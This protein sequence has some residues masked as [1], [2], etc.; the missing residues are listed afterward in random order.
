MNNIKNQIKYFSQIFL[1]PVYMLSH[2]MPR[3]KK[4]WVLGS[5][6]GKRFADNPR[7][8]Y[9][10]LNQFKNG[11]VKAIW[12]SKNKNIIRQLN[13]NNLPA[14]YLYSL[15]GVF[16]C[17]RA[18]V[19]LYDNYS[20]DICF[21]LSGGAVKINMWHGIPLKKI[22][23]DNKFDLVRH[24]ENKFKKFYWKLRRMTDEKPRD[25]VITTS[26]NLKKIFSSA[27]NT[28]NVIV[29][30]YPR[31]DVLCNNNLK[32]VLLE[33]EKKAFQDI[34][35]MSKSKKIIL[36][37]P[38]FRESES[39]FFDII[40]I[41]RFNRFLEK[42]NLFLCI[43]L[44]IKSKL[45]QEFEKINSKNI[46]VID[47]DIDLY[48]FFKYTNILITDYSSTYFDYLNLNKKII[49]FNYDLKD[50]LEDSREMYFDYNKA[51]PGRKVSTQDELEKAILEEDIF[52]KKREHIKNKV[53][54]VKDNSSENLFLN[55]KIITKRKLIIKN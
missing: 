48:S 44:H 1:I 2:L 52:E 12:I 3:N 39:K 17:L 40:D 34:K 42:N 33:N 19:Y 45:K 55:I 54:G 51:T 27:F 14:Y 20:K 53:I 32:N 22:N 36:Y 8:F 21:T 49:F 10:Y 15:K 23:M 24:P 30:G 47:A 9:L 16:Y 7:Y 25:Y 37:M 28:K 38:T 26:K 5:T 6:F 31:N 18:K 41:Q 29:S 50:Y 35:K 11:Q 4:I 43:K 46:Y 13:K